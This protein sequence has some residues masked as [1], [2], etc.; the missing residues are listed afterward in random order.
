[1]VISVNVDLPLTKPLA[2]LLMVVFS[3]KV[4]VLPLDSVALP[5]YCTALSILP[6]LP[7]ISSLNLTVTSLPL[8]VVLMPLIPLMLNLVLSLLMAEVVPLSPPTVKPDSLLS[9]V[10]LAVL[11]ASVAFVAAVLALVAVVLIAVNASSTV[12]LPVPPKLAILVI[13]PPSPIL[14][15]DCIV[16]ANALS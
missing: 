13:S 5:A 15:P 11:A 1:M 3:R 6:I 9:A 8:A 14:A 10:V 16:R 7:A 12:A 2:R 4:M